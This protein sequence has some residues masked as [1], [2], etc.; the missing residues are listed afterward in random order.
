MEPLSQ[1]KAVFLLYRDKL[2][3]LLK[4]KG[5]N[6]L[7]LKNKIIREIDKLNEADFEKVYHQLLEVLKTA[8]PYKLSK[9]ENQAIDSALKE[10]E[11]VTYTHDEVV[12]EARS[13]FPNMK[14]K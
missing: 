10:S 9:N 11:G 13:M 12:N 8:S 7:E 4:I 3:Y 2:V 14:F 1:G 6:I 5:M